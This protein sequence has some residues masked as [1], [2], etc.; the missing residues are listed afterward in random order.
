MKEGVVG[1]LCG[2]SLLGAGK[3]AQF[4]APQLK[5]PAGLT[6]HQQEELE[7]SAVASVF[8]EFRSSVADFLWL[9]ADRY[10]H[11]GVATRGQLETE[12][13]DKK[14]GKVQGTAKH[15]KHHDET[16][17]VP[18]VE[19]D[20][21]GL[22]GDIERQTQPYMD[23]S[24]HEERDPKETIPLFRLM[25]WTNP[26][27]IQGYVQGAM[28]IARQPTKL[29][30]ALAFLQEGERNNPESISIQATLCEMLFVR[31][32]SPLK[33]EPYGR[34][35]LTLFAA[36]DLQTLS[37]DEKDDANNAYRWLILIYRDLGDEQLKKGA[38]EKAHTLYEVARGLSTECLHHYPEDPTATHFIRE[39]AGK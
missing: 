4:V 30:E 16:T 20:W 22:L 28:Q 33:A 7:E 26:H 17:T 21:R 23:M 9:E 3:L 39:Y 27:F 2:I 15:D 12:K 25:T 36:R 31:A 34:K 14:V 11:A 18:N 24:Q 1:V 29:P 37:T 6:L 13:Q 19:S 35:A 32:H 38:R 5:A 10:L 8:G